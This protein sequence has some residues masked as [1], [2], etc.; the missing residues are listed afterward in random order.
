M[1]ERIA[2]L[3]VL[4]AFVAGPAHAQTPQYHAPAGVAYSSLAD[5]GTIA[6]A[7]AALA[8]DPD[9]VELILALGLAQAGRQQYREA[10]ATFTRGI[11]LAPDN[12][13][14]YRW[15]GHRYLSVREL[16]SAR[17]DLERGLAL[18]PA[19]YGCL[20]HLGIVKHVA[21]D[22]EG[23]AAAFARALPIAPDPGERAGSMD[24]SWMALSRAG[25]AADAQA[26]LDHHADPP[27]ENAYTR[28]LRL[29]RG[30]IGPDDVLTP[31]DTGSTDIATLRYGV[32]N[33]YLVRGD[34]ARARAAFE[35]AVASGGWP[36]FGF[37]AAEAELR[38]LQ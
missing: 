28:R 10:I 18:D 6:A 34:T 11:A 31:A 25:R 29:Y 23:A 13:V 19:C 21:G 35:R 17:A 24:W 38:R 30:L 16:D 7:A 36:A 2:V 4:T 33:W 1:R 9:N 8:A 32:G 3:A 27:I 14:L 37:I 5:A 26:V 15:R 12:A 22:Y 20:Y